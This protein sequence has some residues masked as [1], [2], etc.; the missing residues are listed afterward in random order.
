MKG[1]TTSLLLD[2]NGGREMCM[3]R[4]TQATS[5]KKILVNTSHICSVR[6][7][8]G[9]TRIVALTNGHDVEVRETMKQFDSTLNTGCVSG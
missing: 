1:R 9:D 5:G 7:S 8:T 4:L 3:L 2:S 6:E